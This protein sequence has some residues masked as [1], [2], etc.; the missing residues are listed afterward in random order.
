VQEC[1]GSAGVSG[2]CRSER[3]VQECEGSAGVSGQCRRHLAPQVGPR[4]HGQCPCGMLDPAG[5]GAGSNN[6]FGATVPRP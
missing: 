4:E 5:G 3:A 6:A 2:Q 1:E